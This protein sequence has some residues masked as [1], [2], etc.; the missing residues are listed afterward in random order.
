MSHRCGCGLGVLVARMDT[1]DFPA[2]L[3]LTTRFTAGA[4]RWSGQLADALAASRAARVDLDQIRSIHFRHP[5]QFRLAEGVSDPEWLTD[6][7]LAIRTG[8]PPE[9]VPEPG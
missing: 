7:A 1:A 4:E 2:S 8:G 9:R 6:R 5:T 3:A